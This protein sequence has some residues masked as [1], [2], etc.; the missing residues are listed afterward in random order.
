MRIYACWILLCFTNAARPSVRTLHP[1]RARTREF[2]DVI[3]EDLLQQLA[4]DCEALAT[5]NTQLPV[6]QNYK[7]QTYWFPNKVSPRTSFEEAIKYLQPL[8]K[9]SSAH[10]GAEWWIQKIPATGTA[11]SLGFHVDKDESVASIKQYL[12]HPEYSSVLYVTSQGGGTL[13]ID[14]WSPEGN[15][16][17]PL[18]PEEGELSMPM[19]NK[20]IVFNGEL[21]HG[22][23]P[24]RESSEEG[25]RITFL[26]N[27]WDHTPEPPNCVS[28]NYTAIAA[29][30]VSVWSKEE[31]QEWKGRR[32]NKNGIEVPL[33]VV[34][35][36]PRAKIK[37]AS[38]AHE[39]ALPG[40]A[41]QT[42][43]LPLDALAGST[44]T[45]K[46]KKS[47][48]GAPA[49]TKTKPV[50]DSPGETKASDKVPPTKPAEATSAEPKKDKK[51][52]ERSPH[53]RTKNHNGKGKRTPT[54]DGT[55]SPQGR[56]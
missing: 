44:S 29:A 34:D 35:L 28:V 16:Y 27:F 39:I 23:V 12:V 6:L 45:I 50:K 37:I 7:K 40:G 22:V 24:S 19:R 15:G 21:L 30:G 25:S 8:A 18:E 9:L 41:K 55:S 48:K 47:T 13:I 31:R 14:Q 38:Y 20:Y 52:S 36:R 2:V 56:S 46:W 3:P 17:E 10:V 51:K 5:Y 42:V 49:D 43:R 53:P 1:D 26:V 4:K 11:G 54:H 33:S 32:S